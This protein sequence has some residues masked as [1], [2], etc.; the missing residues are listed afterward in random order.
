MSFWASYGWILWSLLL[1]RALE[2]GCELSLGWIHGFRGRAFLCSFHY[3]VSLKGK[4]GPI[5][6]LICYKLGYPGLFPPNL[7]LAKRVSVW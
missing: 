4:A 1:S 7:D 2:K 6:I 5:L 3:I